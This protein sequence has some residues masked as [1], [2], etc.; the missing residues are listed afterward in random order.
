MATLLYDFLE[1][2]TTTKVLMFFA[3]PVPFYAFAVL[4]SA[5]CHTEK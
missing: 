3:L 4:F 2:C 1:F 5:F